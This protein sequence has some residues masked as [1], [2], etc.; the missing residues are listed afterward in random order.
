M[1]PRAREWG[2]SQALAPLWYGSLVF[3]TALDLS[4]LMLGGY[5]AGYGGYADGF[6]AYAGMYPQAR[7]GILRQ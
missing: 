5:A 2:A 1:Q 6:G 3:S 7:L 4:G